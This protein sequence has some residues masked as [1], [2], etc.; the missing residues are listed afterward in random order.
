MKAD[1]DLSGAFPVGVA[2]TEKLYFGDSVEKETRIIA[3]NTINHISYGN[4]LS[5]YADEDLIRNCVAWLRG[6]SDSSEFYIRG[7]TIGDSMLYFQNASQVDWTIV[8]T[9]PVPVALIL[10]VALVVFIRRRHL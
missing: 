1:T 5:A 8:L 4:S 10:S 7:K 2:I 6:E 9:W 3:F